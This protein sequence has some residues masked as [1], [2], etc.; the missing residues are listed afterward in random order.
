MNTN[1]DRRP[2]PVILLVPESPYPTRSGNAVRD[3]Q[4]VWILRK[5]GFDVRILAIRRRPD[6][7]QPEEA[8][9]P[10]GI[11][12]VHAPAPSLFPEPPEAMMWRK[13]GYVL[14]SRRHPF[15]WWTEPYKPEEFLLR[16]VRRTGPT[17]V[18]VRSIFLHTLHVLRQTY[19]GLII[20]DCHDADSH[21][22]GEMVATVDGLRKLGPWANMCAVR[23]ACRAHMRL[24]DEL[25]AVSADDAER[26]SASGACKRLIVVPSGM[27]FAERPP[28][29]GDNTTVLMV[30]SYGYGPN[31]NGLEWLLEN[32]WAAVHRAQPNAM[33]HLVGSQMPE[34]LRSLACSLPAV[35][36]HGL[37]AELNPFYE[38][39]A[40]VVVPIFEGGGTRLKIVEAFRYG[41]A[42][43][44]TSKGIE[45]ISPPAGAA[46]IAD[47]PASFAEAVVSLLSDRDLRLRVGQIA[48][49]Y[50]NENLSYPVLARLVADESLLLSTSV[51]G[52]SGENVFDLHASE[53]ANSIDALIQQ[54]RYLRGRLFLHAAKRLVPPN[55]EILDY[56][57]GPG[58]IALLLAREGFRVHGVDSSKGM[59]SQASSLK[60]SG[61]AL[62][63]SQQ[64]YEAKELGVAR[65]DAIVC[66]SVIEYVATPERLLNTFFH[67]L[68]PGGVLIMTYANSASLWRRYVEIRYGR[69]KPHFRVQHN[70]WNWSYVRGLLTR[71]GFRIL[72]SPRFFEAPLETYP[73]MS[74]FTRL[75]FIGS[76]GLV[77]ARRGGA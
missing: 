73:A 65:Y 69:A 26:I 16:E 19:S 2:G 12:L 30:A 46:L 72:G 57:C 35:Q 63:F 17:A 53:F 41:K 31:A 8:F 67:S 38:R 66:S 49:T 6:V 15:A 22:A 32:V 55:G 45:G 54:K 21:F 39:A 27:P 64:D 40:A 11:E 34:R 71:E 18:I 75:R 59:L 51:P 62:Q 76:L 74:L 28:Y 9:L 58:R 70:V 60:E 68:K 77:V 1:M 37:V 13:A 56:G 44:T 23:R 47:K 43:V 48:Q 7:P 25:W 50:M 20:V 24:A 10:P 42:V 5:L 52:P 4:Q 14:W 36:V 33:L 29:S 61:L 3:A